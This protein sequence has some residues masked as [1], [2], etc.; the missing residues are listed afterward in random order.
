MANYELAPLALRCRACE[1]PACSQ[2]V[3]RAASPPEDAA[4]SRWSILEARPGPRLWPRRRARSP[5]L[6]ALRAGSARTELQDAE[7]QE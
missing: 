4:E 5:C 2:A 6:A 3:L 7:A 1:R